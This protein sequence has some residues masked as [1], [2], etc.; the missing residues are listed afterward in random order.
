MV[1]IVHID[2][3]LPISR[4]KGGSGFCSRSELCLLLFTPIVLIL[5]ENAT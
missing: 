4:E 1:Q 5:L 3:I 2:R